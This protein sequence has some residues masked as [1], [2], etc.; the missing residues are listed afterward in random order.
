MNHFS[1]MCR[2]SDEQKKQIN[3]VDEYDYDSEVMFIG[4]V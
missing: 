3:I 2:T 4:A 1:R